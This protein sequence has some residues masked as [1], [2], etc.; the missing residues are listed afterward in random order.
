[1]TIAHSFEGAARDEG[2]P[3]TPRP[4][5]ALRPIDMGP[6]PPAWTRSAKG[7][8]RAQFAV[9]AT[10]TL[11]VAGLLTFIGTRPRPSGM[12]AVVEAER[13]VVELRLAL[14]ELRAIISDYH[15]EHGA[16]PGCDANGAATPR[17]FE[18]E[19]QRAVERV[20]AVTEKT[21]VRLQVS[22]APGGVP[23]NPLNGLATVRFLSSSDAWPARADNS[24]GW[25]YRPSTGEVR[26]N[27]TGKAF[28]SGPEFWEL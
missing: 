25:V 9:Y 8:A 5:K 6:P 18:R 7:A 28:G 16:Y 20:H 2:G 21:N 23:R 14:A 4:P 22:D 11:S 3:G 27:C 19:W 10:L 12:H 26:A 13:A 15:V 24:T 17:W 1:M